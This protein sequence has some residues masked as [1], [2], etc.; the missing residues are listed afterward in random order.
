MA[1][2][3]CLPLMTSLVTS[4]SAS[5][6]REGLTDKNSVFEE[7]TNGFDDWSSCMQVLTTAPS[8]PTGD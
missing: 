6:T 4:A 5:Q 7:V 8:L 2:D 3:E 1:S